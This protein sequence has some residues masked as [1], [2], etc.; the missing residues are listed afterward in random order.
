V[1]LSNFIALPS[2]SEEC[3][4]GRLRDREGESVDVVS[5]RR[6]VEAVR[7]MP[8]VDDVG[9]DVESW[10]IGESVRVETTRGDIVGRVLC[11]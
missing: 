9:T 10:M 8:L 3:S 1:E 4:L 6:A 5:S 7:R 2:R 11:C